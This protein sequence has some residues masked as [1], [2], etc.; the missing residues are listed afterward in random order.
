MRKYPPPA[1]S[2]RYH[3]AG[4]A[5]AARVLNVPVV[6]VTA[7]DSRRGGSVALD[8]RE[9]YDDSVEQYLTAL[10][11]VLAAGPLA[12]II[13]FPDAAEQ[14]QQERYRDLFD[15]LKVAEALAAALDFPRNKY[16][17]NQMPVFGKFAGT[18]ELR[19][20]AAV[21]AEKLLRQHWQTVERVARALFRNRVIKADDLDDLI[22]GRIDVLRPRMPKHMTERYPIRIINKEGR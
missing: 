17:P 10:L 16:P 21:E 5:I 3:E 2:T 14:I 7:R 11:V 1:M 4:H 15:S 6:A 22:A 12:E 19:K 18:E 20:D 13:R 9:H 8:G